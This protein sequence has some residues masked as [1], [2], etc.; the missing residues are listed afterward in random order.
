M[1]KLFKKDS[2]LQ[3][4]SDSYLKFL[5]AELHTT[6]ATIVSTSLT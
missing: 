5:Q 3:Q 6:T 1:R 4:P 2:L